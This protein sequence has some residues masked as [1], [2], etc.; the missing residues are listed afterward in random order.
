VSPNSEP[1]SLKDQTGLASAVGFGWDLPSPE[2]YGKR[3]GPCRLDRL[4]QKRRTA[5][6]GEGENLKSPHD[7]P[8]QQHT[9]KPPHTRS[10]PPKFRQKKRRPKGRCRGL[11]KPLG[12]WITQRSNSPTEVSRTPAPERRSSENSPRNLPSPTGL[13]NVRA[14][15]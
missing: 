3:S 1:W 14:P 15:N 4:L 11:K 8:P 7:Q 9:A 13:C 5:R 10:A 12:P 2:E 6:P